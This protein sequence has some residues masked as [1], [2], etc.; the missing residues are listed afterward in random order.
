MI[1]LNQGLNL[2]K[3]GIHFHFF[4]RDKNVTHFSDTVGLLYFTFTFSH[5]AYA[6]IQSD[7]QIRK[8]N[9]NYKLKVYRYYIYT[10]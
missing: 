8:S 6:F 10:F 5:L 2:E 3:T 7:L 1:H 4:G 9:Q